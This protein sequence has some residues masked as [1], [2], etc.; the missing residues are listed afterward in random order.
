MNFKIPEIPNINPITFVPK[1]IP[2]GLK[3]LKE[4][5][6]VWDKS[7]KE[8]IGIFKD[9]FKKELF[10]LKVE[11]DEVTKSVEEKVEKAADEMI[12]DAMKFVDDKD[13]SVEDKKFMKEIAAVEVTA[14]ESLDEEH[15]KEAYSAL[16]KVAEANLEKKN[17]N[18]EK[19]KNLDAEEAKALN[20]VA[21]KTLQELKRG[22]TEAELA[23]SL[24][25][26]HSLAIE[27]GHPLG[28]FLSSEAFAVFSLDGSDELKVINAMGIEKSMRDAIGFLPFVDSHGSLG[29]ARDLINGLSRPL[30]KDGKVQ[31]EEDLVKLLKTYFLPNTSDLI[32]VVR[33][34]HALIE[35]NDFDSNLTARLA[36]LID[37]SDYD[38]LIDKL[39]G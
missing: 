14:V 1:I 38:N 34:L 24:D 22:K 11:A 15:E 31:N 20:V 39:I 12:A 32:G 26:Y 13:L 29:E 37:D 8:R 28:L 5:T 16:H 18:V 35:K 25:R 10:N 17:D 6:L 2:S 19:H 4:A 27:H 23:E 21:L 33:T 7:I 30:D 36:F 9:S 3:A